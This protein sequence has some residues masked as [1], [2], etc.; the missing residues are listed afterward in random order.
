LS[1]LTISPRKIATSSPAQLTKQAPF[2][3]LKIPTDFDLLAG[4][5]IGIA[6]REALAGW[7][8]VSLALA[9]AGA[10]AFLVVRVL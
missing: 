1:I 10:L 5:P 2:S 4:Y 6:V 9:A 7:A 8:M 3:P